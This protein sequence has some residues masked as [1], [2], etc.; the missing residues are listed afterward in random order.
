[1]LWTVCRYHSL[2]VRP[3]SW[4]AIILA[5]AALQATAHA[6][7]VDLT[8]VGASGTIN[9]AIY[10]QIDPSS[11]GTGTIGVFAQQ[12]PQGNNTTSRAFN[13]TVNN[14][15]DNNSSDQHNHA[16]KL[17]DIPVVTRLGNPYRQFLLDI[18]EN[19]G[20]GNEFISLD[21]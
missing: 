15:L 7:I 9:G 19:T 4:A 20:G 2:F 12:S 6:A 18:N 17:S 16:I 21:E 5:A 10:E 14:V 3:R 8:T 13:T 1:M 11:T